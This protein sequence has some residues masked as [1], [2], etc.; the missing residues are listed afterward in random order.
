MLIDVCVG[1]PPTSI[2][3]TIVL[4][5]SIIVVGLYAT[6]KMSAPHLSNTGSVSSK[7]GIVGEH[8]IVFLF[9]VESKLIKNIV[10]GI[11]ENELIFLKIFVII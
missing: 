6:M 3:I 5:K 10:V 9:P 4:T 1:F 7:V 8:T 11:K 2:P